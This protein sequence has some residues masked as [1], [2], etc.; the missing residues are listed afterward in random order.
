MDK[1]ISNEFL[2]GKQGEECRHLGLERL[3]I[4]PSSREGEQPGSKKML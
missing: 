1:Q 3:A 4:A 2:R